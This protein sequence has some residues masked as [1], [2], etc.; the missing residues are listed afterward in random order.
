MDTQ[1]ENPT[2]TVA[3]IPTVE[4][5]MERYGVDSTEIGRALWRIVTRHLRWPDLLELAQ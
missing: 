5:V 1:P 4:D 3:N 2:Q